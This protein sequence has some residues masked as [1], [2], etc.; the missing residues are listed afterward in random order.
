MPQPSDLLDRRFHDSWISAAERPDYQSA[1]DCEFSNSCINRKLFPQERT[2]SYSQPVTTTSREFCLNIPGHS[3]SDIG[4]QDPYISLFIVH[5]QKHQTYTEV[6]TLQYNS[7]L[8]LTHSSHEPQPPPTDQT[9]H[10]P[11]GNWAPAVTDYVVPW[12][13]QVSNHSK[14]Y[15]RSDI[16]IL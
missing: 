11:A 5:R 3:I 2:S 6:K 8:T 14:E 12:F 9:G 15:L 1:K 13:D 16:T 10:S 7:L 4:W